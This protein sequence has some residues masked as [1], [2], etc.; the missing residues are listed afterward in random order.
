MISTI[1]V[2]G[3]A[4]ARLAG[5]TYLLIALLAGFGFFTMSETLYVAGDALATTRNIAAGEWLFR[6]GFAAFITT[7][8]L[9]V[10]M[11]WML[12]SLFHGLDTALTRLTVWMRLAYVYLHGAA[13]FELA[14]VLRLAPFGAQSDDTALADSSMLIA[15]HLQAHLDGF[16]LSLIFFGVHLL[17]LGWLLVRTDEVPRVIAYLLTLSGV[18]YI[19]DGMAFVLMT[20]YASF[21][22]VTQGV[23]AV[24]AVAGEFSFLLWLLVRGTRSCRTRSQ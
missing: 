5:I 21:H 4:F 19:V 3:L 6:A 9:D 20:D 1:P 10:L 24:M 14:P 18:A 2:P 22:A 15:S 23:I 17:L 8:V 12:F 16:L 13:I 11:A 7:I